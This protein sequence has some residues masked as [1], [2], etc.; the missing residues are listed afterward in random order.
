MTDETV[1]AAQ[2]KLPMLPL[3]ITLGLL[4]V[5]G[6][7]FVIEFVGATN[8]AGTEG[9]TTIEPQSYMDIVAPL[10]VNA[11][12]ENGSRLVNESYECH[13]CHVIGTGQQGPGYEEVAAHAELRGELP[14]AAYVYESI[15][16]P[17]A[18]VVEGYPNPSSMPQ[19]YGSRLSQAELGDIIAYILTQAES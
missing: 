13:V 6:V 17:N 2:P 5:F 11:D 8:Q 9:T 19:N 10:L 12:V 14:L 3:L 18:F 4:A 1:N 15:V 16:Q 7:I